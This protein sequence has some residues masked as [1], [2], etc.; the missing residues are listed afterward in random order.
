MALKLARTAQER[1]ASRAGYI[2]FG[3]DDLYQARNVDRDVHDAV[4]IARVKLELSEEAF[5]NTIR[6]VEENYLNWYE[7][8]NASIRYKP[9][10]R[11][12]DIPLK[13]LECYQDY[14]L[15]SKPLLAQIVICKRDQIIF[16]VGNHVYLG[17]YL[18]SQ[19]VQLVF[20]KRITKG[21]F[22]RNIYIPL[23]SELLMVGLFGRLIFRP[24]HEKS[25]LYEDKTRIQ[26]FYLKQDFRSVQEEAARLKTHHLYV[27]IATHVL[28]TA[29]YMN[30]DR[31]RVTL[32][33]SFENETTFNTVGA[34]FLD[35]DVEFDLEIMVRRIR[36]LVKRG[37]WQ[38][39]ASNHIQRIFPTRRLSERARNMVDLTLTVVPQKT[40]PENLLTE[41]MKRYE[42]TMDN[43]HYPVYVMAFIF[44]N[45]IHS[46]WM[47]N[48]PRFDCDALVGEE[49]AVPLDLALNRS[50]DAR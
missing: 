23:L 42:F 11:E 43:I 4:M 29:W 32:P 13:I 47:I 41:E 39:S 24:G 28:M 3:G 37:Q 22:P 40:L 45:H 2:T 48:S 18:L 49:G 7:N 44:E 35:I 15:T 38:V 10:N 31:L 9:K 36:R 8:L 34:M 27:V 50:E 20:C 5:L 46:S 30:R 12:F 19:F 6:R 33:V 1:H 25:L 17:G 26:R 16:L 21:I 14:E